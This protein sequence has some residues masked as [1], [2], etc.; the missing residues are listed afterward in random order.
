MSTKQ[1]NLQNKTLVSHFSRKNSKK[2]VKVLDDIILNY[3]TQIP[4]WEDF[5]I[6][7]KTE[8]AKQ[9]KDEI[10]KLEDNETYNS[11][12]TIVQIR[13]RQRTARTENHFQ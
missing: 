10:K 13:N 9:I 8:L 7:S 6:K 1:L 5:Q 12:P 11:L 4:C 3:L 2:Q